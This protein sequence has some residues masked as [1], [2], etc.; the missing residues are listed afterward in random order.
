MMMV[1]AHAATSQQIE[2]ARELFQE[3][4]ASLGVDLGF[5]NFEQE[6]ANLPGDYAPPEGRLLLALADGKLAGCIALRRWDETT[7]E[8][9]RL[10]VRPEFRGT[11]SGRILARAVI[12]HARDIGYQRMLLD[13][14]PSMQNARGLYRSLGFRPIPPYR[15]NPVPGTE[16]LALDLRA[17][18]RTFEKQAKPLKESA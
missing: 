14:L 16:F 18:E 13:T 3:Y 17:D 1:L 10:Y 7:C 4:A 5:Q 12:E 8:M 2:Q 9:K 6:L 11:G 15:Y